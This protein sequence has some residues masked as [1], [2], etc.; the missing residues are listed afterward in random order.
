VE[1]M[2]KKALER[3]IVLCWVLLAICF[4]IK[5]FGGNFFEYVGESDVIEYIAKH[6]ILLIPIQCIL[7]IFGTYLF[8]QAMINHEHRCS[9]FILV[10]FLAICKQLYD[11]N[12]ILQI[13]C[14]IVE[15]VIMFLY[16]IFIF[17]KK[18]YKVIIINLVLI[19]FQVIS[20]ITKNIGIIS[21]PYEHVVGFVYMIDYYIM[22][23]LL[24]LYTKK[25]V[26]MGKLGLWFL[27]KDKEQLEA[28]KAIVVKKKDKSNKKYDD[29]INKID[30]KIAKC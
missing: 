30:D 9:S 3:M 2:N 12:A 1:K 11:V 23:I 20:L 25:G 16:P 14:Y 4:V 6:D 28:Y 26:E 19:I 27:S 10:L 22:I 7:Y 18:W 21:F 29:K 24:Y 5:I 13:S 15:F 17:K 8:Y